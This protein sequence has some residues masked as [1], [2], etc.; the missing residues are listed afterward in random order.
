[1]RLPKKSLYLLIAL[2]VLAGAAD[3][4]TTS[5]L[6][7]ISKPDLIVE[8]FVTAEGDN[9]VNGVGAVKYGVEQNCF[10]VPFLSTVILLGA[11][12]FCIRVSKYL[13]VTWVIAGCL[14][15]VAWTGAVNNL[16]VIA[17]F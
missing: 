14:L 10:Y 3:A 9:G 16:I 1:V 2:F 11:V 4:L 5:Y 15:L 8:S 7:T 17:T 12:G 6:S 13:W